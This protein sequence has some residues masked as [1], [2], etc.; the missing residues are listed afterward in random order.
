MNNNL[1]NKNFFTKTGNKFINTV[2]KGTTEQSMRKNGQRIL[3]ILSIGLIV[4]SVMILSVS[5]MPIIGVKEKCK[6]A[7]YKNNTPGLIIGIIVLLFSFIFLLFLFFGQ[8]FVVKFRTFFL[9]CIC[10][11]FFFSLIVIIVGLLQ[12]SYI[13]EHFAQ[14]PPSNEIATG[15]CVENGLTGILINGVC[16]IRG[17]AGRRR[18]RGRGGAGEEECPEDE[19]CDE[20]LSRAKT[21]A[22]KECDKK[23]QNI[24]REKYPAIKMTQPVG[25]MADVGICQ[26]E[27][28]DNRIKFGYSHPAFG[29]K[30]VSGKKLQNMLK[31]NP[32]YGNLAT[33][34]ASANMRFKYNPYQSTEC[35]GFS[36]EDLLKYDLKCKD[37]FGLRYGVKNIENFGCPPNDNR[38]L[39]EVDYQMGVPIPDNSTKCVPIG[40]DMNTVCENKHRREKKNKFMKVGYKSIEFTGCPDGYQRALCDG[41]YYDGKEL[42]KD[43]TECFEQSFNANR[44]CKD[45]FGELSFA[46][47]IISDNCNP[48]YI[49]AICANNSKQ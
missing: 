30:C 36:K 38:G 33:G 21:A 11:L 32:E 9:S 26:Y 1:K 13:F 6:D 25:R 45:K 16:Y 39:C 2:S 47:S 31:C 46:K 40:T 49:R 35:Y 19:E 41:N 18:R 3:M 15:P 43:A 20:R 48:G 27:D 42:F 34:A 24:M 14:L 29:K 28:F 8:D 5:S 10:G 4:L 37:K 44:K 23:V 22:S 17:R 7:K 12:K